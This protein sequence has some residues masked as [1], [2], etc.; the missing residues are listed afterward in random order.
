MKGKPGII[1]STFLLASPLGARELTG[2]LQEIKKTGQI[3][4][5]L[6]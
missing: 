2:T 4:R 5:L 6:I 3:Q 1:L